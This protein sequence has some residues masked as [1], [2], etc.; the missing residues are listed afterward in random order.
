MSSATST[1]LKAQDL[2][3]IHGKPDLLSSCPYQ[4][5]A[6]TP[7]ALSTLPK[8]GRPT[9]CST[10]SCVLSHIILCSALRSSRSGP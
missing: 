2:F 9:G 10:P 3:S 8:P 6:F 4:E 1:A 5:D 7:K